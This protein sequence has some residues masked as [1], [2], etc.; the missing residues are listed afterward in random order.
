MPIVTDIMVVC[1]T[2]DDIT[3]INY[4][5]DDSK[6]ESKLGQYKYHQKLFNIANINIWSIFYLFE[7]FRFRF[8]ES[9]HMNHI[10]CIISYESSVLVHNFSRP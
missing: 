1:R 9:Y 8:D 6:K 5:A 3:V 4:V 10:V 7:L 2:V